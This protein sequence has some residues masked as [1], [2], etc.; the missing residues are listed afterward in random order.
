MYIADIASPHFRFELV[1]PERL[2]AGSME[3]A[4]LLPGASGDLTVLANHTPMLVEL[5]AG[6]VAISRPAGTPPLEFFIEGGFADI[7]NEHCIVLTPR[8]TAL[9]NFQRGQIE[10][11][12]ARLLVDLEAE[13]DATAQAR[14]Q[15]QLAMLRLQLTVATS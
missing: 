11:K 13:Q 6:V 15:Q 2:E 12:I 5:R 1:S 7:N 8:A 14:L 4:V 3:Q 10:E 9:A